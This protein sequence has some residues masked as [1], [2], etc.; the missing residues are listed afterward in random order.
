MTMISEKQSKA[1]LV[2]FDTWS[3]S[4]SAR[5]SH[6]MATAERSYHHLYLSLVSG[7]SCYCKVLVGQ[8]T[9]HDDSKASERQKRGYSLQKAAEY[10]RDAYNGTCTR[11][12][13]LSMMLLV[14]GSAN[15]GGLCCFGARWGY[16][17][18]A[19]YVFLVAFRENGWGL[20]FFFCWMGMGLLPTVVRIRVQSHCSIKRS[21][22]QALRRSRLLPVKRM[23]LPMSSCAVRTF[24]W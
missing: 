15:G 16:Q 19:M 20:F 23:V 8:T 12:E 2:C 22:C 17:F 5:L 9:T 4:H 13:L 21:T 3:I 6:G 7:S 10:G 11:L 14:G 18:L 24:A 1:S